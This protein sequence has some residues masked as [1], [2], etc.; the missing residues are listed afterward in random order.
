MAKWIQYCGT[1][2]NLDLVRI[3]CN[4]NGKTCIYFGHTVDDQHIEFDEPHDEFISKISHLIDAT[5]IQET[6]HE[7]SEVTD[8]TVP[9]V[10][11]RE[12]TV[13]E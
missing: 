4:N 3:I 6:I 10:V 8:T 7:D 5:L 11:V 1:Y 12:L 13:S 9:A 2:I